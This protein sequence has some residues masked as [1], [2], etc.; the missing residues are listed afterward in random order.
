M[1][2]QFSHNSKHLT[3]LLHILQIYIIYEKITSGLP[4]KTE[5]L[6]CHGFLWWALNVQ[7]LHGN[8]S[9]LQIFLS[10]SFSQDK[11]LSFPLHVCRLIQ[12][13]LAMP[14]IF[15]AYEFSWHI[16]SAHPWGILLGMQRIGYIIVWQNWLALTCSVRAVAWAKVAGWVFRYIFALIFTLIELTA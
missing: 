3:C 11:L 1:A 7:Q 13:I 4:M 8:S 6:L 14:G 5:P 2:A 10:E 9:P 12:N 15:S 16:P